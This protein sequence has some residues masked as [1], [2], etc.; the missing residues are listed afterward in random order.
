MKKKRFLLT[1]YYIG[2][3]IHVTRKNNR[4]D[5][6][7]ISSDNIKEI[8]SYLNSFELSYV[9]SYY[10]YDFSKKRNIDEFEN[11]ELRAIL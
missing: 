1:V 7:Q 9:Y 6:E 10:V 4:L 2:D 11:P 8:Y 3:N 5:M